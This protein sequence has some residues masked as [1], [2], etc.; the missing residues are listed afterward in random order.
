MTQETGARLGPAIETFRGN[1]F[2][3]GGSLLVALG[4]IA[5]LFL[6]PEHALGALGVLALAAFSCAIGLSTRATVHA[7]GLRFVTLFRSREILWREVARLYESGDRSGAFPG[8]YRLRLFDREGRFLWIDNRVA[9]PWELARRVAERTTPLLLPEAL[10]RFETGAE[11]RFGR[12]LRVRK[13]E[14]LVL[15]RLFETLAISWQD[16]SGCSVRRGFLY[17][18]PD[19]RWPRRVRASWGPN[20]AVFLA[21]VDHARQTAAQEPAAPAP[22]LTRHSV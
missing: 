14:G 15:T 18:R 16:L 10:R 22:Q 6:F 7:E 5:A 1:P 9:R 21:L 20:L 11:I 2:S 4:S 12:H 19:G 3:L 13:D 8:P 17:L